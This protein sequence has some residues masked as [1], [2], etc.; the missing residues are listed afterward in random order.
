MPHST[1]WSHMP[2]ST[3]WSHM[4]HSTQW[5][6]MPHSTQWSHMPHST[7]CIKQYE[8]KLAVAMYT[9]ISTNIKFH[10]KLVLKKIVDVPTLSKPPAEREW[11]WY[12]V[13]HVHI[14]HHSNR[15]SIIVNFI[16]CV[17]KLNCP[18]YHLDLCYL[19]PFLFDSNLNQSSSASLLLL[20]Y[21]RGQRS[22][23][24]QRLRG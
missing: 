16:R 18:K 22:F 3:Q 12:S 19:V 21:C 4:P 24:L 17:Y 15:L 14:N 10:F 9:C 2:H 1:Q 11:Y 7:Q 6:H 13:E 8:C 23:V 5:S 20:T